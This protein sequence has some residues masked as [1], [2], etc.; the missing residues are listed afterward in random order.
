MLILAFVAACARPVIAQTTVDSFAELSRLVK[1]GT[2][3]FVQ[4]EKGERTKGK[5]TELSDTS[6]QI[7]TGGVSGRTFRFAAERVTRVSTVDSRLNGFLIGA[8]AG[9]VPGILV[10]H[11]W[12]T[13]LENEARDPSPLSYLVFG[14][15]LS[16]AGGGIGFAIDGAIDGQT[17]VF[18]RPGVSMSIKF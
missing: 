12:N 3:V 14:L 17:L 13:Y 1:Q 4:D 11:W 6:L 9:A 7:M 8:I 10:G 18:R 5:I 2:V 16:L 15:P